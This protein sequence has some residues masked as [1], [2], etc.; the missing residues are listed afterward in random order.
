MSRFS[1]ENR[2]T[3]GVLLVGIFAGLII[4]TAMPRAEAAEFKH[5]DIMSAIS[6]AVT[7]SPTP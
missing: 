7:T 6:A 5:D 1:K 4:S 2:K 3:V